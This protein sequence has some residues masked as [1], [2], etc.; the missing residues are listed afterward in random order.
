MILLRAALTK[1]FPN[2]DRILSLDCDTLVQNNIS[3]LWDLPLDNYYFAAVRE[4]EK[5]TEE[6]AY[7]NAGLMM[8]NLKKIREEHQ[9]DK[10]IYD[11]NNCFR[12]YPE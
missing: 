2:L 10:Y 5:S 7:I 12:Y 6:Y 9:D 3:E 1:L 4:P 8:F 11:L